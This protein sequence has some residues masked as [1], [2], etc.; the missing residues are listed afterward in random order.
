MSAA[1]GRRAATF[2]LAL[3]ASM[4][5]GC[6]GNERTILTGGPTVGQLK[7]SLSHVEF[8]NQ[9][10][11]K[12]VAKL[13]RENRSMENRLVDEQINSGDLAARL[14]DA[15]NLLRDRGVDADLQVGSRRE[16]EGRN[17]SAADGSDS[18]ARTTSRPARPRRKPPFAQIS[19]QVDAL[20]S[21]A[22]PDGT[23][24]EESG[25]VDR[26]RRSRRAGSSFD[27]DLDHHSFQ[28]SPLRWL[29]VADATAG[30]SS[31]TR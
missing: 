8:E 1:G 4:T 17:D 27:D 15:R 9:Q 23:D 18:R 11:K 29:P 14:D 20:P 10:L 3:A 19:G 22:P 12:S 21:A 30:P 7:T 6:A 16:T 26:K 28:T 24:T 25:G 13:E 5:A 31:A 2:A